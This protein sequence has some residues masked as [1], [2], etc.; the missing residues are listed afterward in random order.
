MVQRRRDVPPEMAGAIQPAEG[1]RRGRILAAAIQAFARGGFNGVS[2]REIAEAAGVTD[3]L[4]FYHFGSKADLYLA[5]VQ[6]QLEKLR[7]GLDAALGTASD[8]RARPRVFVEV[9]LSYFLDLEP[10]LT[11]TLREISGLPDATAAAISATHHDI[12]TARLEEILTDGVD[13]GIF[14][15]LN[16][17]AC[18]LAILGILQGFIRTAARNPGRFTRDEAIAQVL[19][20]YVAG[21]RPGAAGLE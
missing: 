4:L 16:V 6:D 1:S 8:V 3:P 13:A 9:Y 2:T 21:L 10:G 5:A 7:D 14:R 20:H 18:A 17:P 12:V 19:D 15:P 11:V